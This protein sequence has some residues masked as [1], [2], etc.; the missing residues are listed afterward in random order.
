VAEL[1]RTFGLPVWRAV[2][3]T[4]R[5]DLPAECDGADALLIEPQAPPGASRPGGNAIRM[6]WSL[7][8]SWQAPCP[9]TLAGGLTPDNVQEAI[10]ATG[11]PCVDVSSGVERSRGVKDPALIHAFAE[12]ARAAQPYKAS[13]RQ[14]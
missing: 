1:R 8:E 14:G 12:A 6:D 2:G 11:A 9:W 7:L 4:S 3:V 5:A 13:A 10:A